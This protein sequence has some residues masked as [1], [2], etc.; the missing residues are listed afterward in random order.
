MR[1]T[2][3]LLH[4]THVEQKAGAHRNRRGAERTWR[5]RRQRSRTGPARRAAELAAL[6]WPGIIAPVISLM[7]HS[8]QL[9]IAS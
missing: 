4:L 8:T 1:I 7:R 6:T 5:Y 2:I 9:C 3:V